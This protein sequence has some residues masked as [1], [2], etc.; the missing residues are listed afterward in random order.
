MSPPPCVPSPPATSPERPP[1]CGGGTALALG[2]DQPGT[3][4]VC[5]KR[6]LGVSRLQARECAPPAPG[7]GHAGWK[8]GQGTR[9]GDPLVSSAEPSRASRV[10]RAQGQLLGRRGGFLPHQAPTGLLVTTLRGPDPRGRSSIPPWRERSFSPES[11][12]SVF[13]G[14]REGAE[15]PTGWT[16]VRR[17]VFP[18]AQGPGTPPCMMI[19]G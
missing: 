8:R 15:S 4:R 2:T 12:Q 10:S 17:L 14:R 3:G 9:R 1:H 18:D 5:G 13:S 16:Q 7:W 11:P 6:W 19:D